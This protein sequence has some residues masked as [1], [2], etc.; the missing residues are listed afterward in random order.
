[1]YYKKLQAAQK[2]AAVKEGKYLR[3]SGNGARLTVS[4]IP[5]KK[6]RK[7]S[8]VFARDL[9][10]YD[11]PFCWLVVE[12]DGCERVYTDDAVLEHRLRQVQPDDRLWIVYQYDNKTVN[13][14]ETAWEK[15]MQ[16]RQI[17]AWARDDINVA[18]PELMELLG[19]E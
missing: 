11:E 9:S 16:V 5:T 17:I 2:L 7:Y 4:Y 8:P 19:I 3:V 14:I 6:A 13:E 15:L 10:G 18:L 1:M 12:H